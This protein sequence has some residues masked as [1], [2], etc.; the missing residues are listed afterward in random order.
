MKGG[1]ARR[2]AGSCRRVTSLTNR[3]P[4]HT[5]RGGCCGGALDSR[6]GA[7]VETATFQN[8]PGTDFGL[9]GNSDRPPARGTKT[10]EIRVDNDKKGQR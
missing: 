4:R 7:M 3:G 6:D 9:A 5:V 1:A 8:S 2:L 10:E